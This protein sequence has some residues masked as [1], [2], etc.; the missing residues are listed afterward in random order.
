LITDEPASS[1]D[2][3]FLRRAL[4]WLAILCVGYTLISLLNH[5]VF[6][7]IQ[8]WPWRSNGVRPT[9]SRLF[10]VFNT[11]CSIG[12]LLM[13]LVGAIGLLKWKRW[14]R[15]IVLSG[16]IALVFFSLVST[17]GWFVIYSKQ[18]NAARATTRMAGPPTWYYGWSTFTQWIS[19]STFPAVVI[20][21]MVQTEVRNLWAR[22][23]GTGGFEVVP[24]ARTLEGNPP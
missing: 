19:W 22:G 14:S 4:R 9:G 13:L 23:G 5:L 17:V 20:W 6:F 16:A 15:D 11:T 24:M 2:R 1:S 18:L 7:I 21:A 12:S 10:D 8:G 3:D